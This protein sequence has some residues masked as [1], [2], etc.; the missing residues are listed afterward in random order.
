M[1]AA[2]PMM[3]S[4]AG[5]TSFLNKVS[6]WLTLLVPML[7]TLG[8][9]AFFWGL[10]KY[11]FGGTDDHKQGLTIMI[12]GVLA[13]FVMASLGGLV[14]MLQETTGAGQGRSINPPCVGKACNSNSNT[15]TRSRTI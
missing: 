9:I 11:L 5:L 15:G 10:A 7:I 1:L 8:I 12:M 13:V 2:M 14:A 3:A 4:A 6:S